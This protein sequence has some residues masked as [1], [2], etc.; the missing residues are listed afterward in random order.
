MKVT[1]A[2]VQRGQYIILW[3]LVI[4]NI[5]THQEKHTFFLNISIIN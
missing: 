4:L 2:Y 5:P 3:R 1:R